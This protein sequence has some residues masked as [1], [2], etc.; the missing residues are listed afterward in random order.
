[1]A[2]ISSQKTKTYYQGAQEGI[3]SNDILIDCLNILGPREEE[4]EALN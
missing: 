2:L 1:M 4:A 3:H